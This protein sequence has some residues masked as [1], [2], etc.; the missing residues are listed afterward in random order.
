MSLI[1]K[2][3]IPPIILEKYIRR[4]INK[5]ILPFHPKTPKTIFCNRQFLNPQYSG[6]RVK[7]PNP[8]NLKNNQPKR[9]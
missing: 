6:E 8:F 9:I 5:K 3:N 2:E 1:D 4:K 7:Q